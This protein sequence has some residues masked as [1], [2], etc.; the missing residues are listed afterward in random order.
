MALA[1]L[2]L[3]E[4]GVTTPLRIDSGERLASGS[5]AYVRR[6]TVRSA[7]V[8][9]YHASHGKAVSEFAGPA[10]TVGS[11]SGLAALAARTLTMCP[12]AAAAMVRVSWA[13]ALSLIHI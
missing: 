1:V 3:C 10:S 7:R 8:E 6:Q 5:T 13:F 2:M 12:A 9:D 4:V 11:R